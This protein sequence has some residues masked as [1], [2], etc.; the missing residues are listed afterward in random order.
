MSTQAQPLVIA[1]GL[2]VVGPSLPDL[3]EVLSAEALAFLS[4][5]V[6][7]F[8]PRVAGLLYRRRE[9]QECYD[10]GE[11]PRFLPETAHI[12]E[13]SW[14]V[15]PLPEDLQDRRVEI[16]GP[17]DRKMIINGLN[18]GAQVFM[19]DFEDAN[20]PTWENLIEGQRNLRDAVDG[21]IQYVQPDTGKVYSLAA[22][23]ATL[24]VRP[25]GWH[26]W[27]KH[28]RLEDRPV[29]AALF[30]FGLFFFHNARTLV[31]RGTGTY[32]YLPK[33]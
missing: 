13:A 6:R 5:L 32:F 7:E 2:D 1:P 28:V 17:V 29:P 31:E 20:A 26:L 11:R 21:T 4:D 8:T 19:A 18:S 15:A 16:T 10:A 23:T 24:M 33:M 25:R 14:T 3:E 22:K 9:L 12:R 27:E 30:D